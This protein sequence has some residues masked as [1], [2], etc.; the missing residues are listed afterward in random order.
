VG[1]QKVIN[2]SNIEYIYTADPKIDPTAEKIEDI[3]WAK[4]R[5]LIPD[6]W[7]PG[8]SSPFDPVAAKE[9][10][11]KNIEVASIDGSKL[12]SLRNYLEGK[13]FTGTRIHN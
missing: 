12:S 10:E 1:S 2:L 7:D 8:L 5:T 4:F 9:A 3:T 11:Q 13:P 6:E